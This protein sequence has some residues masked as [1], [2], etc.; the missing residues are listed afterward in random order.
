MAK[1]EV[2]SWRVD[3]DLKRE[4]EATAQANNTSV[5]AVIERACRSWI[6]RSDQNTAAVESEVAR[7]RRVL[8]EIF[9]DA[10]A[11]DDGGPSAASATNENVRKAF[12]RKLVA[13][14]KKRDKRAR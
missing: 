13:D 10:L 1:T 12:A 14:R 11:A 6:E 7:R 3:P 5:G 8:L 4:L 9:A 2:Y